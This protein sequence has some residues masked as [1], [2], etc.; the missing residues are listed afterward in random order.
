MCFS[1][2][3]ERKHV[4]VVVVSVNTGWDQLRGELYAFCMCLG[5]S[6]GLCF[7]DN[8]LKGCSCPVHYRVMIFVPIQLG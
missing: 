6:M 4:Y 8:K 2:V 1:L 3:Y 7:S 5:V